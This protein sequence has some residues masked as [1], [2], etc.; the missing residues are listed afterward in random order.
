[1]QC[2][3]LFFTPTHNAFSKWPHL[4]WFWIS[5]KP[6]RF[7]RAPYTP[8]N[9]WKSFTCF[10]FRAWWWTLRLFLKLEIWRELC[11]LM[12]NEN[13]PGN[14]EKHK[15]FEVVWGRPSQKASAAASTSLVLSSRVA[16]SD[17]NKIK[18]NY[19]H[20]V[21]NYCNSSN[22]KLKDNSGDAISTHSR[23]VA[24]LCCHRRMH[25]IRTVYYFPTNTSLLFIV[26][27]TAPT[28]HT[29][30][31]THKPNDYFFGLFSPL[32]LFFY[33]FYCTIDI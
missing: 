27:L 24:N 12:A 2:F 25:S 22:Q 10:H 5:I 1:M 33:N 9:E 16:W 6:H 20:V 13:V 32:F 19:I 11:V 17:D 14:S 29:H 30:T 8:F 21:H 31:H 18:R 26:F 7:L 23:A 3:W 28:T 4:Q 15:S